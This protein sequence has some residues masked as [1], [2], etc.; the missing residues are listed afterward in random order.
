M[1]R[2]VAVAAVVLVALVRDAAAQCP[3]AGHG[4]CITSGT[5]LDGER[6]QLGCKCFPRWQGN[7]CS[8]RQCPYANAWVSTS[9][10]HEFAEC[11]ARGACDRDSGLCGCFPGYT[12][13]A[14]QR[15]HCPKDCSGHG[16]CKTL[17]ELASIPYFER[18]NMSYIDNSW[19][20]Y[21]EWDADMV[22]GCHCDPE[23]SGIDCSLRMCPVADDPYTDQ[24]KTGARYLEDSEVQSIR[25]RGMGDVYGEFTLTYLDFYGGRWTTRAVQHQRNFGS[26]VSI[27]R[28][29]VLYL[30]YLVCTN[31]RA[32]LVAHRQRHLLPPRTLFMRMVRPLD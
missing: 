14:C 6:V 28:V 15:T 1:W 21:D 20:S 24:S 8:D 31:E 22:R 17:R 9:G 10:T 32:G 12:G 16:T 19:R 11:S 13:S 26:E 4:E 2:R 5:G 3:C 27:G 30:V 29:T 25:V 23:Y 7:D 18:T